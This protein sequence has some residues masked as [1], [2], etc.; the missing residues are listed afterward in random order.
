VTRTRAGLITGLLLVV[1]VIVGMV[2][3]EVALR[4][5]FPQ[6]MGV[7][8][9]DRNGLALHWP[10]LVTY[11]P[12]FGLSVSFNSAGMRDREH[13]EEKPP[14]VFRVLILGDSFM[15]ALQLPFESSFPY[16]LERGLV[17]RTARRIEVINASVS[18]WGTDD[19]V[20]YLNTH[21]MKWSPDLVL[22]AM[23]LHNDI[24]DNLRERFHSAR[25]GHLIEKP[26]R[27]S[28]FLEYKIIQLRA[29]VAARLHTYQL[30]VRAK[31]AREIQ[32]E[33]AGLRA[34]VVD[35]FRE[36][37]DERTSKGFELT[38]LLLER[39][40][41]TAAARG[42]RSVVALLPL[43]AQL[44]ASRFAELARASEEQPWKIDRPQRLLR[45]IGGRLG[46]PVIDLLPEFS[47]WT[48]G[49]RGALFLERD[50]HWN[51]RGHRLAADIVAAALVERGMI[52]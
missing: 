46:I 30:L 24:N 37:L 11:L 32:V 47:E 31:R 50:G 13:A 23:T 34:H 19:E 4:T 33:A 15:E 44:S 10:G 41:A 7:W 40:E 52:R 35:L 51:E 39:L 12:Q 38:G 42:G 28:S 1:A 18:G 45:D 17:S 43:A 21:G 22:V 3:S 26:R 29:V 2:V 16:L 49:G 27:E 20:L 5:F 36:R 14:G 9:Q 25:N 48:A 6:R 8:H